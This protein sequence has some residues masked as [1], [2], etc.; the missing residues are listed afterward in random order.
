[1]GNITVVDR[2]GATH[3]LAADPGLNIMEI[4]RDAGLAIEAICGGQC[5]CSTCHV[6]I[7]PNWCAA[8]PARR[9]AEQVLVED[10]G[11]YQENS[12]LSCQIEY[13]DELDGLS[14]TL[15]P[16]Y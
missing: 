3:S 16:E 5:I 11:H 2:D 1:M 4:L 14:L 7:E 9:D 8:L 15:A 6:Y 13:T 12:R 10:T